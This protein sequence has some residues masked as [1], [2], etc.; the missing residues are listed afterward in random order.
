MTVRG[1][2]FC[3]AA[4]I[5]GFLIHKSIL[6][7][8]AIFLTA[9]TSAT[10]TIPHQP[11]LRALF[12]VVGRLHNIDANLLEAMA[13]VESGD[14]PL[15]VSPDSAL[16]LM[17]LMPTTASAFSVFDPFDPVANVMGAADFLNY[18]RSRFANNL[19]AGIADFTGRI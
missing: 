8:L 13:Q 7:M 3:R 15:S 18:L 6:S 12:T 19:I 2:R 1:T 4:K 16:G 9:T 10:Q 5:S 14:N 17:Q 11:D